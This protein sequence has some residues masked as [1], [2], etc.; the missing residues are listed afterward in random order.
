MVTGPR[1]H[2]PPPWVFDEYNDAC[3][4]ARRHAFRAR[5]T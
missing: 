2:F 5:R 1:R 4:I 3:F